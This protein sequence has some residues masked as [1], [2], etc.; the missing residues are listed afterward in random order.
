V[1]HGVSRHVWVVGGGEGTTQA[2]KASA[3]G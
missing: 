2:V 3:H 1:W